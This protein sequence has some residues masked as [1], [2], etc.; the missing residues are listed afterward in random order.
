MISLLDSALSPGIH[1]GTTKIIQLESAV[2]VKHV[3]WV[4]MFTLAFLSS[5]M[6]YWLTSW[7]R[8]LTEYESEYK[9][10]IIDEY[11]GEFQLL[12]LILTILNN[13]GYLNLKI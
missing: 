5:F 4:K 10:I 9:H 12:C 3:Q 11:N 13:N 6:Y 7:A 2:F 8:K 1:D